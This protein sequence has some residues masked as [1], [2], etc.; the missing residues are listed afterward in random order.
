MD[1]D[2]A[3]YQEHICWRG[4]AAI[5]WARLDWIVDCTDPMIELKLMWIS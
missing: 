5:Y 1:P 4:P 3:L 2:G